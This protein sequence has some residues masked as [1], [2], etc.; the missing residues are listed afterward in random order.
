M[1]SYSRATKNFGQSAIHFTSSSIH[2]CSFFPLV[3][4]FPAGIDQTASNPKGSRIHLP[5]NLLAATSRTCQ[6]FGFARQVFPPCNS[7]G[8]PTGNL[9]FSRHHLSVRY[10]VINY[11]ASPCF[12]ASSQFTSKTGSALYSNLSYHH[13]FWNLHPLLLILFSEVTELV[14]KEASINA[15]KK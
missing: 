12:I 13:S 15:I 4:T 7:I 10:H 14:K 3:S 9:D 5:T 8:C 1:P 2:E 11:L 6:F